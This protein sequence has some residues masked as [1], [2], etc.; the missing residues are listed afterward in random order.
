M[1]WF[2]SMRPREVISRFGPG[3]WSAAQYACGWAIQGLGLAAAAA[4]LYARPVGA[5]KEIP[6]QRIL[7]LEPEEMI[8]L[9]VVVGTPRHT[10]GALLDLRL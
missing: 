3:G 10:G 5:F 6:T 2:F 9:A 7:G 1:I 4:G 8:V